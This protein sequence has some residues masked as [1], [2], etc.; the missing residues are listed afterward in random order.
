[1]S[2]LRDGRTVASGWPAWALRVSGARV[3]R[4]DACVG[5]AEKCSADFLSGSDHADLITPLGGID[6]RLNRDRNS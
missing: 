2:E 3:R 5:S 6:P 1:M 4:G